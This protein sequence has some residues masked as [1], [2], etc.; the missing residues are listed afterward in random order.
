MNKKFLNIGIIAILAIGAI[1]A[2]FLY[3]DLSERPNFSVLDVGKGDITEILDLNGKVKSE[4]NADLGFELGGRIIELSHRVGD[5]VEKGEI[6][7]KAN[8][9]DLMADYKKDL[10]LVRSAQANLNYYEELL[11]K[12]K[13][14]LKSLKKEDANTPDKDAQRNQIDASEAQVEAQEANIEAA[15]A[16]VQNIQAQI[17]ETIIRAPFSGVLSKQDVE[18]GE[19]VPNNTPILTLINENDFKVEAYVSEMEAKKIQSGSLAKVTLDN[20]DKKSYAVRVTAIDPAETLQNDISTYK[21]TLDFDGEV[22]GLKSGTD[23]NVKITIGKKTGVVVI[24]RDALFSENEEKF[25]YISKM[26]IRER[27]EV[28]VGA[29]GNNGMVEILSGLKEGDK[30]YELAN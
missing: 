12:E 28:A 9:K 8:D 29:Y 6:L 22:A 11:G 14:K 25:V 18:V 24:P 30:I 5:R 7:A 23:A 26:G 16:S 3:K 19:V 21:V 10:A 27:Q 4:N 2:S 17:D 15:R 20:G 1:V 13:D